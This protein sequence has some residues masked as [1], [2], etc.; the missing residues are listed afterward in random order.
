MPICAARER[1]N[2]DL[3]DFYDFWD[4]HFSR[5][6]TEYSQPGVECSGTPGT[7]AI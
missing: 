7:G 4:V 2:Y 5:G 1:L 6:A 3:F